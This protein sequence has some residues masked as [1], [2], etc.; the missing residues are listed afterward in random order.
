MKE[1]HTI[2]HRLAL[3]S[4][5]WI[6]F[7][8]SV[9]FAQTPEDVNMKYNA[10]PVYAGDDLGVRFLNEY[11]SLKVWTPDA[12]S[13]R[14]NIYPD[15]Q[16]ETHAARYF[17][18]KS[19]GGTWAVRL[20][21]DLFGQYY[22][23]QAKIKEK[24]SAEVPD[25]YARAVGTNG[26]RGQLINPSK[27]EPKGWDSDWIPD[28]PDVAN[29]LI[30]E[31]HIRDFSIHPESGMKNKGKYLAFTERETTTPGGTTTGVDHLIEMGIT[32]VHLLP[33]FDFL[34]IDESKPEQRQFNWGYDPQNYNVPEG[35]YS[36]NPAD[37]SV[38]ILEFKQMVKSLHDAGIRVIMDVVYNHTGRTDGLTFDEL[39]PGYFYRQW[40][41]GKYSNASG[42]GNE[43]ASERPMVRK[44]IVESLKYW[45]EEYHI[46]GFRFD[47]MAIHDQETMREIASTLHAIRPD[48]FLYGEGWTAD[49]SPLPENKRSLKKYTYK[50]PAIAAFSDEIRDGIKGHW[51]SH[52][53]KGFVSGNTD[54]KESVKFGI[55]GAIQH[56]DI[57]YKKVNNADSAW[58]LE[59]TQCVAYVSCHDNHTLYDK[60][61][62]A[63]PAA[64]EKTIQK[65]H[66][67]SNAI[68][69]TSQ[70]IPFLHAGVEFMRTKDG[71]ENSYKSPDHI[72]QLDWNM[73]AKNKEVHE[74]YKALITL[75]KEH[76]A[77]RMG[78]ADLVQSKLHFLETEPGVIAYHIQAPENDSWAEVVVA[79]NGENL[80]HSIPLEGKW[81]MAWDGNRIVSSQSSD[82]RVA[83]PAYS[84]IILYRPR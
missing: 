74:A 8:V 20:P 77:F 4:Y 31:L 76:P 47:L 54:L 14:L 53:S 35:S 42:C 15:D 61:K 81:L 68:V 49:Q 24:W 17:F 82:G 13:L 3:I 59:P 40:N 67:L 18:E 48:M 51:S 36:T 11:I 29:I 56:P 23:V 75:R 28:M 78:S 1:Q 16:V 71:V 46:D 58:A 19:E 84:A 50:L 5:I 57:D 63:N 80:R 62:L 43:T 69:L 66:I 33:A 26:K 73:L 34:S 60:L 41:F 83:I 37:G 72:N 32:H 39:A 7:A 65:M 10:Y 52:D 21:N 22:T 38:R 12:D 6:F 55:V 44:Y 45:M 25:P 70:A 79:F 27:I 2:Q 9:S 64:D 30:Y